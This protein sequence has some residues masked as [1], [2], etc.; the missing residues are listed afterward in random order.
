M[1]GLKDV[2]IWGPSLGLWS[3]CNSWTLGRHFCTDWERRW[4]SGSHGATPMA[5]SLGAGGV[6]SVGGQPLHMMACKALKV[7]GQ[8]GSWSRRGSR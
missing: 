2:I 3:L 6:Q 4:H 1:T 8:P 7:S 5:E